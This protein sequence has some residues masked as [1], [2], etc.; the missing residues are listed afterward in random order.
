MPSLIT[1]CIFNSR[2]CGP[3]CSWVWAV[4][5]V[6]VSAGQGT[7]S[8]SPALVT[9]N[10]KP[11]AA[12]LLGCD[13]DGEW[14]FEIDDQ[15]QAFA[16]DDFVRWGGPAETQSGPCL[17]LVG[18]GCLVADEAFKLLQISDE[19]VLLDS[20]S[21]GEEMVLP[22]AAVEGIV[23]R[24]HPEIQQRNRLMDRFRSLDRSTDTIILDNGDEVEGTITRLSESGLDMQTPAGKSINLP[25]K[26]LVAMVFNPALLEKPEPAERLM[27][28][29]L[30]DGSR[31]NAVAWS[32]GEGSVRLTTPNG[33]QWSTD[34]LDH[35]EP[36]LIG[37]QPFTSHVVYLS[38]LKPAEY[39]H[40]PYLSVDWPHQMDR[41]VTGSRLKSG[42]AVYEKGIGMHS[43]ASLTYRL[44]QPYR[45]FD[46]SL[47]IDDSAGD[48]GSVIFRVFVDD[49]SG[50]WQSRYRS[51]VIRGGQ[52]PTRIS[53]DLEGIRGL[54]LMVDHADRG[55]E[56]D[57]ADW[58]DA[59]LVPAEN[60]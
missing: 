18:G 53:I 5:L 7:G 59:R 36:N 35:K 24:P 20:K 58:L 45:R 14:I 1:I 41:N 26:N 23:F 28:V 43:D 29:Q 38:D 49:G 42:G 57:R 22:L 6:F 47:G 32:G 33:M 21:L 52:E 31:L 4:L 37:L 25:R 44:E 13:S 15:K 16:A 48:R 55:D 27:M 12:E 50:K 34:I 2:G 51:D 46:A 60:R 8:E 17:H 3:G 11:I 39:R 9:V 30:A 19:Q 40:Q 54:S 56:M 10:G